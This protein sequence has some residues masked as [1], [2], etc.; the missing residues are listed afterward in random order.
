MKQKTPLMAKQ[1]ELDLDIKETKHDGPVT[2]L[3]K[4]FFNDEA[5]RVHFIALLREKLKAFP[6]EKTKISWH[7]L[8]RP[9]IQ[10]AQT[11]G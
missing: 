7:C 11:P 1:L 2:C 4:E 5:R 9:I 6:L 10:L 8:I 3:G